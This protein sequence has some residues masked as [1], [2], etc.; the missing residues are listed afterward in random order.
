MVLARLQASTA[1]K[2]M[3]PPG[4]RLHEL[5]GESKGT[6]SVTVSGPWP[7]GN[8]FIVGFQID[9]T[10]KPSGQRMQ[11]DEVG[12]YIVENGKIVREEFF[13]SGGA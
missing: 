2:D 5:N 7:H 11:L 13:Y 12:L 1:P 9:M 4:L 8:R 6:W 3:D 10:N